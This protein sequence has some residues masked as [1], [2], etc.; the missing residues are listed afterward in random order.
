MYLR[1]LSC[2]QQENRGSNEYR[3]SGGA[4]VKQPCAVC[5][6]TKSTVLRST[7]S[8]SVVCYPCGVRRTEHAH[9]VLIPDCHNDNCALKYHQ[10]LITVDTQ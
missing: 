6:A 4:R 10:T 2:L 9:S 1:A 3:R 7:C 5:R 8:P